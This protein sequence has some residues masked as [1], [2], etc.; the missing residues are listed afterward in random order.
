MPCVS[1]GYN[2]RKPVE[3]LF[4]FYLN[5]YLTKPGERDKRKLNAKCKVTDARQV[6]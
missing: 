1:S 4:H 3:N 2:K 6:N 5:S